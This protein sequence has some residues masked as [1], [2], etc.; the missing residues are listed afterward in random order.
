M[1]TTI[2]CRL[3]VPRISLAMGFEAPQENS[4]FVIGSAG[5]NSR[6]EGTVGPRPFGYCSVAT[7]GRSRRLA[8]RIRTAAFFSSCASAKGFIAEASR[9]CTS[10]TRRSALARSRTRVEGS[11]S[12]GIALRAAR[13]GRLRV[14]DHVDAGHRAGGDGALQR[15]P[16]LRR[17]GDELSLSAQRLHPLVVAGRQK[18]RGGA[19]LRPEQ[20]HLR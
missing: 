14:E 8:A 16:D 2:A 7:I 10:M 5:S 20:L 6:R 15:R 9:C 3:P 12:D 1:P 4:S 19:L 13:C 11:R 18:L 17:R